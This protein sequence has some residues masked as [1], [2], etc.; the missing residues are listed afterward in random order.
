[1]LLSEKVRTVSGNFSLPVVVEES[2]RLHD[3]SF[4]KEIIKIGQYMED[5]LAYK[6]IFLLLITFIN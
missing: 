6:D 2:L 4:G 3:L 1:M 5:Y